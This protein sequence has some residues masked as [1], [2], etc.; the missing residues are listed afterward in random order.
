MYPEVRWCGVKQ[1]ANFSARADPQRR[2]SA[3][4]QNTSSKA[5]K[6]TAWRWMRRWV[7]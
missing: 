5:F 1:K 4:R 3:A 7:M 2:A 6:N